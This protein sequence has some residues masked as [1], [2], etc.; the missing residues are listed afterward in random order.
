M[1]NQKKLLRIAFAAGA[2]TDALAVVPMVVPSLAKLLW[3]F[4]DRSGAYRFPECGRSVRVTGTFHRPSLW[5][6]PLHR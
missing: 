1:L 4:E 6:A 3:G 2:I 5:D